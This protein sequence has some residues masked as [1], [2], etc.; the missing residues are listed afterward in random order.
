MLVATAFQ[1]E[2]SVI[3]SGEVEVHVV[4]PEGEL[5]LATVAEF[6]RHLDALV[7]GTGRRLVLDLT[8]LRFIDSRG[9][10]ALYQA[11]AS[12]VHMAVVVD[13]NSTVGRTLEISGFDQVLPLFGSRGEAVHNLA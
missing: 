13:P 6:Q 10:A 9:V 8:G 4:A 5:D 2:T 1:V 11:Y 7:D 3:A 12:F